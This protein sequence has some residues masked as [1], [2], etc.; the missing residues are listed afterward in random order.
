MSKD[1][2]KGGLA[3]KMS[4]KDIAAKFNISI[5][6]IEKELSMGTK[7]EKEHVKTKSLATEIA[8]DHLVEIP[9]Y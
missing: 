6:K 3:D 9:D 7:V 5:Q 8:M 1:K 4:K 2:L